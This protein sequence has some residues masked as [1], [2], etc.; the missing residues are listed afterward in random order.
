MQPLISQMLRPT[1][2][3]LLTSPLTPNNFIHGQMNGQFAPDNVDI[4]RIN[5]RE[6]WREVQ[7]LISQMWSRWLKEYSPMLNARPKWTD[8]VKG[9][10]KGDIVLVLKPNLP[11][12]KWPFRRIVHTCPGIDGH[13]GVVKVHCGERLWCDPFITWYHSC[14]LLNF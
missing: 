1:P 8:V 9:L 13:T 11:R 2:P 4:T 6:R 12:E 14:H 5:P 10:K 7:E 3:Y